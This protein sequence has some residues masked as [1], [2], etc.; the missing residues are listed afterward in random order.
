MT[1]RPQPDAVA[2]PPTPA[3]WWRRRVLEP[4][5][6]LL[7][8]GLAP[9]QLALTVALGI[10]IGLIPFLGAIT[11]V[12]T[13]VA[14]RLRLNMAALQLV[15]HLM[16]PLQLLLLIPLLRLGARLMGNT[17]QTEL[18]LENVRRLFAHDWRAALQLLWRAEVG[19]LALWLV[20][21]VPL[22]GLVYFGLRPV[23]RRVQARQAAAARALPAPPAA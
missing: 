15:S 11:T 14:L 20:G 3:G 1:N 18:T 22:V 21:S 16:T 4:V 9:E 7:R 6:G 19:A 2:Q 13:L 10:S 8:Q 5:L 23:L 12:A 17:Q